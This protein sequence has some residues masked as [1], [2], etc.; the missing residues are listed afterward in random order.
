MSSHSA[1]DIDAILPHRRELATT[2]LRRVFKIEADV[3]AWTDT[4]RPVTSPVS[5]RLAMRDAG[6]AEFGPLPYLDAQLDAAEGGL[7]GASGEGLAETGNV[8]RG[9]LA[10]AYGDAEERGVAGAFTCH[11][12]EAAAEGYLMHESGPFALGEHD[13][14]MLELIFFRGAFREH[15]AR[16]LKQ[17]ARALQAGGEPILADRRPKA[18]HRGAAVR[19]R[20]EPTLGR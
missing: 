17:V 4:E 19:E 6:K 7:I 12:E 9:V 14:R 15:G 3:L 16:C 20:L 2:S 11:G 5:A 10:D 13:L 1:A 18:Q 8:D